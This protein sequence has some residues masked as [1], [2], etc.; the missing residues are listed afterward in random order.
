M[1]KFI[2]KIRSKRY[3]NIDVDDI[4]NIQGAAILDVRSPLEFEENHLKDS[5]NIPLYELDKEVEKIIKNKNQPIIVYCSS[6]SRS[7]K[8]AVKLQ[9]K[10][11]TNIYNLEKGL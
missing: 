10:G 6:G 4:N 7:K 11:Y 3:K 5:I 8:A 1:F 2:A 9:K